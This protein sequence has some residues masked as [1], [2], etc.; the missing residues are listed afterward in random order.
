[1]CLDSQTNRSG[2]SATDQEQCFLFRMELHFDIGHEKL[3]RAI[4]YDIKNI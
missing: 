2:H 4:G 3:I 1:M